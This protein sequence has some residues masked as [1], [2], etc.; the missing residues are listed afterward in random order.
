MR[1]IRIIRVAL[2]LAC[3]CIL[4]QACA[5]SKSSRFY[6]L[7]SDCVSMAPMHAKAG[8][9]SLGVGP[10]KLPD[11]LN[12]SQI[13]TR[14]SSETVQLAEYDRWA[15]PLDKNFARVLADDLGSL[16]GTDRVA[17]FPLSG[18]RKLDYQVV[19]EVVRFDG[20]CGGKAVLSVRY[21]LFGTDGK[22]P[23]VSKKAEFTEP[24]KGNT[25]EALVAAHCRNLGALSHE[26]ASAVQALK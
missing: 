24:V 1:S 8:N 25:Y 16:L 23:L 19:V 6:I 12:R 13:V 14:T 17:L 21:S 18:F 2:I 11:Y 5:S 7:S 3:I 20:Q 26:I 9:L 4:A 22:E 15:E 10:V